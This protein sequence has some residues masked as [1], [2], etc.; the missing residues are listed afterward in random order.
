[1][2]CTE[3]NIEILLLW[4]CFK[5]TCLSDSWSSTSDHLMDRAPDAEQ[6]PSLRRNRRLAA[7]QKVLSHMPS[8]TAGELKCAFYCWSCR[9]A[10]KHFCG[11]RWDEMTFSFWK[12]QIKIFSVVHTGKY[13]AAVISNKKDQMVTDLRGLSVREGKRKLRAMPLSLGSKMELRYVWPWKHEITSK[14]KHLQLP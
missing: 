13:N 11:N 2:S 8:C 12:G 9:Q 4:K 5:L 1:M 14:I 3:E 10:W 6:I 7:T